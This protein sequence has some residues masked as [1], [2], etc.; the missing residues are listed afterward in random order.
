MKKTKFQK[1]YLYLTVFISGAVVL[2]I[3]IL[4]TRVLAPFY[5]STIFVWS[6]L[7]TV[8]LGALALGYWFGGRLADRKHSY[9][10][11]WLIIIVAGLLIS[12]LLQFKK[13]II[14]ASDDLGLQYGPL[15]ASALLFG[16][17]LFLMG[18]VSPYAI[19]LSTVDVKS[20]GQTAGKIFA[21]ATT[22]SIVGA[23]ASGF[24][25]IP[26]MT[27]SS[28]FYASSVLLVLVGVL[29]L[30][31]TDDWKKVLF[32]RHLILVELVVLFLIAGYFLK[33]IPYPKLTLQKDGVYQTTEILLEENTLA[34]NYRLVGIP[35]LLDG[36]VCFLIDTT[37]QGCVNPR[38]R[39][40]SVIHTF[41]ETVQKSV[42]PEES[43]ILMLGAGLG[44]QLY[45]GVPDGY[46]YDIVDINPHSETIYELTGTNLRSGKDKIIIE[47]ARSYLSNTDK[48]YDLIWNDLFGTAAPIGNLITLEAHELVKSRLKPGGVY[49]THLRGRS[50][51]EDP[52]IS[53]TVSTL[54]SVY[55]NVIINRGFT[56]AHDDSIIFLASDSPLSV[57]DLNIAVAKALEKN[58]LGIHEF[59][60]KNL[61]FIDPDLTGIIITDDY[62]PTEFY[63][64]GFVRKYA[65]IAEFRINFQFL[66]N[67]D[68][69]N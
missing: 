28:M 17:P 64:A 35:R 24:F 38:E 31:I 42:I 30:T 9:V 6:S 8:T 18:M 66:T 48:K 1:V 20:S 16:L 58:H 57:K 37:N 34:G 68:F 15:A 29:G 13:Y 51:Q 26:L 27:V 60:T 67:D 19:R 61:T 49:L 62:N 10:I 39:D 59:Y 25:L 52:L 41:V 56:P 4:G 21:F 12:A 43:D 45:H 5:G 47:E 50:S 33:S 22:G 44:M 46:S 2:I 32:R 3:E 69:I 40:P 65:S 23:L 63:W 14:L 54:R 7:I 55:E 53:S 11:F 36:H